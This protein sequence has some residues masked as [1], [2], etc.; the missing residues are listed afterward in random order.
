[1]MRG[2][3]GPPTRLIPLIPANAGTHFVGL[4]VAGLF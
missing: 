2:G 4:Y 3:S 1:M